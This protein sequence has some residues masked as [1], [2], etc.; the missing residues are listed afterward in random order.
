MDFQILTNVM[1]NENNQIFFY[2]VILALVFFLFI[3]PYLEKCY[4]EDKNVLKEKLENIFNN[5][6]IDPIDL[7]KCSRSCCINS[8]WPYPEEVLDNDIDADEL[9]NYVPNNFSCMYGSN[10]NSGC[11]CLTQKDLTT[12]TNKAGNLRENN[13]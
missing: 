5:S 10:I 11:L 1:N 7:K 3:M 9:K 13:V 12:L 8:G 2:S 4:M 6:S